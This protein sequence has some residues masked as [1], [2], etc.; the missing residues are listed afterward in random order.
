[1]RQR[2]VLQEAARLPVDNYGWI[3]DPLVVPPEEPV[4]ASVADDIADIYR[5][6]V[7]GLRLDQLGRRTEAVWHWSFYLS[8]HW[9]LHATGA[10][11]ALHC[12][13]AQEAPDQFAP[14]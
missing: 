5:D 12:W 7:T 13:L 2:S 3:F 14:K 1:M 10:I 6:V 11:R 4:V 9:G 8:R